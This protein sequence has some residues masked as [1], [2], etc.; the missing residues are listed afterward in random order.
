M[1]GW[2]LPAAFG[3]A[4]LAGTLFG[5][6]KSAQAA[7]RAQ[8]ELDSRQAESDAWYRRKYNQDYS[9][10]SAGQNMLRIAKEYA[11]SLS[12]RAEG[13]ASMSGATQES[14]AK[15][16]E[17]GNKVVAEAIS[18]MA[19]NDTQRKDN[20]DAAKM[21]ADTNMSNQRMQI[22]QAR[23]NNIANAA[24]GLSN[25][26][27][28]AAVMTL[29]NGQV[30]GQPNVQ[31]QSQPNVM[32]NLGTGGQELKLNYQQYLDQAIKNKG[33]GGFLNQLVKQQKP[34]FNL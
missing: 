29:P 7:K 17:Q 23:A 28:G 26:L 2:I 20:L 5:G 13:A 9:S 6:S 31:P 25:A 30:K 11:Q 22:E 3:A 18:N 16:K 10:T 27:A 8:A 14:L 24:G 33:M 4:S 1:A 12:Q 32:G 19:A 15:A 34:N 21:Q